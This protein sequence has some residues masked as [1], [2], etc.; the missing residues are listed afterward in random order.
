VGLVAAAAVSALW[1]PVWLAGLAVLAVVVATAVDAWTVHRPPTVERDLHHDVARGVPA[2]FSLAAMPRRGVSS[3]VRQPQLAEVRFDP[4]EGRERIEG[5]M[6]ASVRGVHQVA[7]PVTRSTGPLGLAR[8]VHA[9]G[10][11][12]E[13]SAHADLPGARNLAAAVRQGT[14]ADAGIRR[15]PLGLGTNFESIRDY[16]PDDDIRRMN[17]LAGERAGRPMV[18]QYRQDTERDVWCLVDAGRL[19]SSPDG[20]RTRLDLTL[21]AVAAVAAVAEVVGD[22]VGAVVFDDEVRMVVKPTRANA[23]GLVRL[24]DHLQPSLVDSDYESAFARVA[25][26]KRSLVIVFT[27]LLDQA[28]SR[29]LRE[30]VGVLSRRHAVLVAGVRDPDLLAA[31]GQNP[32]RMR[33]LHVAAVATDLLAER[34]QVQAEL[35]SGGAVVVDADADL[36]ASRCVAAYLSLKSTARL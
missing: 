21:D 27:D 20:D 36:L 9:H 22:R 28:A 24:M 35:S 13:V 10:E 11:P 25:A 29:P 31:V 6:S 4:A 23:A 34:D 7:P 14:F 1:L 3:D 33:D 17:L 26:A 5:T 19:L 16:T 18:N 12:V 2:A 32:A 30:A 15:G 8:W